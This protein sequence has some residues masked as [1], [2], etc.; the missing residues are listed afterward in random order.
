MERGFSGSG[1]RK[2]FDG[3]SFFLKESVY[4]VQNLVNGDIFF[5]DE[6]LF[7]GL[8]DLAIDTVVGADFV[9]NEIDPEG[10]S[11]SPGRHRTIK[12]FVPFHSIFISVIT[13]FFTMPSFL[14]FLAVTVKED[15]L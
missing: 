9:R 2:V 13:V 6:S 12:M 15:K 10:P 14:P 4:F 11:Q 5:S 8:P 7:R 3:G 1:K